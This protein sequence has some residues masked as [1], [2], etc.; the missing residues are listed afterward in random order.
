[1]S[2]NGALELEFYADKFYFSYGSLNKLVYSP[3]LFYKDY[4]LKQREQEATQATLQGKL[5]HCLILDKDAF[6]KQFVLL[7]GNMPSDNPK[8]VV[9]QVF[10]HWSE[11]V[12][13]GQEVNTNPTL[14]DYGDMILDIL[15]EINLHQSLKTDQQRLEK[16]LSDSNK[17]Y[18]SFLIAA[19]GK[20]V[21]D[22]PTLEYCNEI[23]EQLK[24]NAEVTQLL[25]IDNQEEN[26]QV[27][28]ELPIQ[29][30]N[31]EGYS[32]GLKGIVDNVVIDFGNRTIRIN[33]LKTTSK[34]LTDFPETVEFFKLW[35]QAVLYKRMVIQEFLVNN[36]MDPE[37]WKVDFNFIVVDKYKQIYCYGVS[38][39]TMQKWEEDL[40][41]YL[42]LAQWHYSQRRYDLPYNLAQGKVLL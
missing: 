42:E 32:F 31:V 10:N 15:K 2:D 8:K 21:V 19:K 34:C 11:Q 5:I 40:N 27:F 24:Q 17:E 39:E 33:D 36:N 13:L 7:P 12:A 38:K 9:D 14:D 6:Y 28:N 18:F 16:M 3:Q 29:T 22:I 35:L 37:E 26:V 25:G 4:V 41:K 1:M 30:E 20:D 23:A